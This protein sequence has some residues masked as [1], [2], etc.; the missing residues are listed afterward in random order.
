[1]LLFYE[2]KST[3]HKIAAIKPNTKTLFFAIGNNK[4]WNLKSINPSINRQ[5]NGLYKRVIN[6]KEVYSRCFDGMYYIGS[7]DINIALN[8]NRLSIYQDNTDIITS[9]LL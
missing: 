4:K 5:E 6:G 2:I 1:L 8:E 3:Y 7:T 9:K